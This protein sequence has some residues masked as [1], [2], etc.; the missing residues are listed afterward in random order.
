VPDANAELL[1]LE[2]TDLRSQAVTRDRSSQ[3]YPKDSLA[4]IRLQSYKPNELIYESDTSQKQLAVFSEIYYP[5]GWDVYIDDQPA[6][7]FKANYLLRA[8]E[9]PAGKHTIRFEFRPQVVQ[10]GWWVSMSAYAFFF[11]FL[12]GQLKSLRRV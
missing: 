11:V 10:T 12:M 6:T 8:M 7:H 5:N 9:I 2:H 3:Q 4:T 1:A